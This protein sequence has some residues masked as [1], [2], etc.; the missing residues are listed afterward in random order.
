MSRA[1]VSSPRK[2]LHGFDEV[3]AECGGPAAVGPHRNL[4]IQRN[5]VELAAEVSIENI[6]NGLMLGSTVIPKRDTPRTPSKPDREL[7]LQAMLPEVFQQ[8]LAFSRRKADDMVDIGRVGEE[9]LLTRLRVDGH[10]RMLGDHGFVL[11]QFVVSAFVFRIEC[12]LV[13]V[14]G[15]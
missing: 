1:A 5:P 6:A 2:A 3:A 8:A 11:D 10:Q 7:R 9:H 14:N 4:A 15:P 12:T 13:L